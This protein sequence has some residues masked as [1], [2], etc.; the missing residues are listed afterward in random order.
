MV[1]CTYDEHTFGIRNAGGRPVSTS[2]VPKRDPAVRRRQRHTGH[3]RAE[4]GSYAFR[5]GGRA[6]RQ[7]PGAGIHRSRPT[8]ARCDDPRVAA[9]TA[10]LRRRHVLLAMVAIALLLALASPWSGRGQTGLTA[11]GPTAAGTTLSPHSTY[12]VQP[13]DTLWS[14]AERLDPQGDPR[15]T[16]TTLSRQVGSDTVRPGERLVLP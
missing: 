1:I 11:P 13:G 15:P 8:Y 6:D 2:T 3:R 12:T 16:M 10:A 9:R 7:G 14:I 5:P 4:P